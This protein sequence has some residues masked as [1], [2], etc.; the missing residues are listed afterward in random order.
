MQATPKPLPKTAAAMTEGRLALS[1]KKK[2]IIAAD[3]HLL[4]RGGPGSGKTTVA[5]LKADRIVAGQLQPGQKVLFLSF[6]R[7]TVSRVL[8]ALDEHSQSRMETR[9]GLDVDTYHAFFWR[10]LKTHGYLL[11]LPRR[12][13]ILTPPAEA[14]ALSGV[15]D[16]FGKD[17][18]LTEDQLAEKRKQERKLLLD[19]ARIKG[20]ICFDLFAE[21]TVDLLDRCMK[22]RSLVSRAFP[23]IMLDEF[24]DTNAGQW[25]VVRLLGIESTLIA[26]ADEQQQI[27]DFI[28]ADPERLNHFRADFSPQEYDLGSENH[29]S[30]GTEIID[31]GNDV[32]RGRFRKSYKGL[33]LRCF[34]SNQNQA[35]AAL[36]GHTLQARKRLLER[37]GSWSLAVLVPT[38]QMMRD[39]SFQ[40][41]DE[42]QGM[43][44]IAHQAAVDMEGAILAA[45]IIAFLLQ[46][47]SDSEGRREF[48]DLV[49]RFFLGKGGGTPAKTD[50][51]ASKAIVSAF[52]KARGNEVAGKPIGARSIMRPMLDAYADC[53]SAAYTG[54]PDEDWLAIRRALRDCE[55]KHL[56]KV[57]GE[58]RNV[59]LLDRGTQLREA[60][61]QDWRDNGAYANALA[62]VRDAFVREHFA[63]ASKPEEGV[64]VMNMHKA[65]GK[66]FDEV[67]IFEGWPRIANG[68]IVSNPHRILRRNVPTEDDTHARY[69]L[70]VSAT[71]AK[72]RTTILTPRSDPCALLI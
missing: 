49:S 1:A 72:S 34:E 62:I 48:V 36:K 27:Y 30:S 54:N 41:R 6:A 4:V 45:E 16:Q 65:K 7:A 69:N 8:E 55:C 38:K 9:R 50:I 24:Q 33:H 25:S 37:G 68:K 10:L 18:A 67:V 63:S 15:R 42:G 43:A 70:R 23:V 26:L 58:A 17:V 35:Y 52:E 20:R 13:T 19:L 56:D 29:R 11:G 40:F 39:V 46:P 12:L 44:A 57:A 5:I 31:F 61:S 59:R 66:Q 28:G 2:Q 47:L 64:I 14:I 32:V 51:K 60:L 53:V 22:V 21:F 3:G 71:R